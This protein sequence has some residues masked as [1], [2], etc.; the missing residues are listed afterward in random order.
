MS[1]EFVWDFVSRVA[2]QNLSEN[3]ATQ[4][5]EAVLASTDLPRAL[6]ALVGRKAEGNPFFVEEVIKSLHETGAI[7]RRD[8]R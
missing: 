4:M 5:T 3:E 6:N 8:D 2:L 1:L 7:L